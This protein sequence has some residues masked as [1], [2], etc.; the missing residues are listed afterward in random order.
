MPRISRGLIDG[1]VYH[2]INRGNGRQVIFH[3]DKDYQAFI[4]IM[5][6]AKVN[7]S[8]K[9]YAY[10]LMP[11]HFHMVLMPEEATHLSKMMQWLMTSHVRRYHRHYGT[12]GHIWQGRYKS[13]LIQMDNHL[14]EVLRYVESNPLRAGLVNSAKDW[15]WSSYHELSG[16]RQRLWIDEIPIELPRNWGEYVNEPMKKNELD[17]L[18]QSVN[19]QSP[20]GSPSWQIQMT[21]ELGLESTMRPRGRPAKM[22]EM[23]K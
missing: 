1:S 15:P 4:G 13:F 20:Y 8:V 17:K 12:S 9:V 2:V 16:K 10:C 22:G 3:K 11:N 7:Y 21:K 6:E 23:K 14:L 18:R 5:E 19:R